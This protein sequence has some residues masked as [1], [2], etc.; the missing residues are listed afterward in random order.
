MM[1][2]YA[3]SGNALGLP[4][5]CTSRRKIFWYF[6]CRVPKYELYCLGGFSLTVP[7]VLPQLVLFLPGDAMK[8]TLRFSVLVL[9]FAVAV[10][11]FADDAWFANTRPGTV[12]FSRL[13]TSGRGASDW[14]ASTE[15]EFLETFD[16]SLPLV[17][18]IHGNWLPLA[19]AKTKVKAFYHRSRTIGPHRMLFW[20]W[21]SEKI[22]CRLR[23]DAQIKASRADAQSE[24]LITFLRS[25][26]AGSKVSLVGYSFGAKLVCNTL[27]HYAKRIN[28]CPEHN[29][30][31][32]TVLLAAA[33]DRASL[34]P[35][36]KYG[37]ALEATEK[38]LVHFNPLDPTL[39]YYPF[40]N[41]LGGPEALGK[42]NVNRGGMS[43]EASAKIKSVNVSRIIG[44]EHGFMDSLRAFLACRNDF[45]T[46]ALFLE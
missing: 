4:A 39:W 36:R 19:E 30:R 8:P 9:L 14:K 41:G 43:A 32:R 3:N 21:P 38:M 6:V 27:Q 13:T 2:E 33:M 18:I 26:P 11:S 1:T 29:L 10:P 35:G 37:N 22:N 5:V 24:F 20:S 15:Q 12:A 44:R 40:L 7:L 16:S 17:I 34:Q 45:K 23:R 42:E 31:I 25:L 46:Y 28:E